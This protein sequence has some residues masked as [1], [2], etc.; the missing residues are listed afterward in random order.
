MNFHSMMV[1]F[2]IALLIMYS[3]FEL[4]NFK[5]ITKQRN[6]FYTKA[7]LLIVG[8]ITA[9]PALSTGEML[10]DSPKYEEKLL[11]LHEGFA[12]AS[13]NLYTVLAVLYL[14][15]VIYR[16]PKIKDFIKSV[17]SMP[18][19][20]PKVIN[21]ILKVANKIVSSPLFIITVVIGILLLTITGGLG[22]VLSSG[23]G[24]D[25]VADFFYYLFF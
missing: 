2:P 15:A 12:G 1:H 13:T 11:D 3:L 16:T 23:I 9:F 21:T 10:E 24:V 22:G 25:P 4:L 14:L 17:K 7:T 20:W 18:D 19:W 5:I 6:W 8:V